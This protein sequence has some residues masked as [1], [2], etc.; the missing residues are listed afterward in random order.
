MDQSDFELMVTNT[1][2]SDDYVVDKYRELIIETINRQ[3]ELEGPML[4]NDSLFWVRNLSAL[5]LIR[6][7]RPQVA[8]LL[9]SK[10]IR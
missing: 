6:K 2:N 1:N 9:K 10:E 3:R 7:Y 4:E 8:Q 5:N